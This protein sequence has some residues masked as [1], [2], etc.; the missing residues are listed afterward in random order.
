MTATIICPL[1]LTPNPVLQRQFA[2]DARTAL[3]GLEKR[4]VRGATG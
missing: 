4:P 1:F 3:P 2:V